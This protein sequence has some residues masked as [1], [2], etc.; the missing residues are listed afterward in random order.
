MLHIPSGGRKADR[1]SG[2]SALGAWDLW[3]GATW[4]GVVQG[5]SVATWWFLPWKI[6]R[7]YHGKYGGFTMENI[8]VLPWKTMV[9]PWE[10]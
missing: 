8:E 5:K 1:R 6:W 10:R 3:N 7:F 2:Q 9:L 4:G